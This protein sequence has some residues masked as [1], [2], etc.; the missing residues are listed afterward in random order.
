MPQAP[1]QAD[2]AERTK[3]TRTSFWHT[4]L[5]WRLAGDEGGVA[6]QATGDVLHQKMERYLGAWQQVGHNLGKPKI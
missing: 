3:L 5:L 6:E 2:Q 4:S 1:V